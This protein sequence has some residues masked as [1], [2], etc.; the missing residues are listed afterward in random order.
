MTG[1]IKKMRISRIFLLLCQIIT[2]YRLY[3]KVTGR[4]EPVKRSQV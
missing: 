4:T 2:F 1:L 3:A